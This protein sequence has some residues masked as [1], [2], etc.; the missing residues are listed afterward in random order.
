MINMGIFYDG[1]IK[2][3]AQ[4]GDPQDANR[5][6][7]CI[8]RHKCDLSW[9]RDVNQQTQAYYLLYIQQVY[10]ISIDKQHL[11]SPLGIDTR[12]IFQPIK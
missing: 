9:Q 7:T 5:E 3:L 1:F 8:T 10:I 2:K 4:D 6:S 11:F 12:G